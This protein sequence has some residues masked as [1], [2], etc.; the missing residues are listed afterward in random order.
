MSRTY[1]TFSLASPG[2]GAAEPAGDIPAPRGGLKGQQRAWEP[3]RP[4]LRSRLYPS[5]A[6]GRWEVN[7]HSLTS[8]CDWHLP[9]EVGPGLRRTQEALCSEKRG[10]DRLITAAQGQRVQT[11]RQKS[12]SR[13]HSACRAVRKAVRGVLP[14]EVKRQLI[15][16]PGQ[17][18]SHRPRR[19]QAEGKTNSKHQPPWGLAAPAESASS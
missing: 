9:P 2:A 18:R 13:R 19:Q 1:P 4:S 6:V 3:G 16:S 5:G 12:A 10:C 14:E 15:P 8:F 17:Q 11:G 7:P